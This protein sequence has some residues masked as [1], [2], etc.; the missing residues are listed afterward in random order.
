MDVL[1]MEHSKNGNGVLV[2]PGSPPLRL[3]P[4]HISGAPA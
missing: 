1:N 2:W 4:L 3:E